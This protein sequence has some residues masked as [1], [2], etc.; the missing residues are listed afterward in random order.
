M[1]A[2]RFMENIGQKNTNKL[3]HVHEQPLTVTIAAGRLYQSVVLVVAD[4]GLVAVALAT[5][6][7][8]PLD[9]QAQQALG[10]ARLGQ[11]AVGPVAYRL[12]VVLVAGAVL[13]LT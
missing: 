7:H 13:G 3:K 6:L 10:S 9:L 8:I 4:H 1:S 11:D 5:L 2:A 12:R